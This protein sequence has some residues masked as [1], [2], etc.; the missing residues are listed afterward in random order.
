ML[1]KGLGES[2]VDTQTLSKETKSALTGFSYEGKREKRHP[3][4]RNREK[5]KTT[6]PPK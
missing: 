6:P 1:N 2:K 5:N 4:K 3:P